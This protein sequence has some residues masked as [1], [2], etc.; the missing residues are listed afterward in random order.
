M[1]QSA[2]P[3]Q[4]RTPYGWPRCIHRAVHS[5]TKMA[6]LP[7]HPSASSRSPTNRSPAGSLKQMVRSGGRWTTLTWCKKWLRGPS[8]HPRSSWSPW[9]SFLSQLWSSP[10]SCAAAAVNAVSA[11]RSRSKSSLKWPQKKSWTPWSAPKSPSKSRTYLQRSKPI[12]RTW[13]PWST[14]ISTPTAS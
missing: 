5:N 4:S 14:N 8:R 13:A 9:V 6:R 7:S 1:S 10:A 11:V 12:A 2:H 3:R